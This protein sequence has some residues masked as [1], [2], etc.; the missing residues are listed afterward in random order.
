L[1]GES[2][3]KAAKEAVGDAFGK[4][5][6]ISGVPSDL[7]ALRGGL[8]EQLLQGINGSGI[9]QAFQGVLGQGG[10]PPAQDTGFF[11]N[12]IMQ[13][14]ND[15]FAAQRG[16]A[17]GQAKESA[18]N[19]TG[20]GYNNILG[21]ATSESL[22]QQQALGAQTLLGLRQQELQRQQDFLRLLFGISTAGVGPDQMVHQTGWAESLAPFLG[23]MIG[24]GMGGQSSAGGKTVL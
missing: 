20:S 17:L 4:N 22:A 3:P 2:V 16:T 10:P 1:G 15:L 12:N 13:P 6:E 5:K 14:Y 19:L 18:G 9:A 24:K 8:I 21:T 7:G 23:S 11:Y